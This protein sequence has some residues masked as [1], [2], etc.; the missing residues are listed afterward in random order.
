MQMKKPLVAS[1]DKWEP[2][3]REMRKGDTRKRIHDSG[4]GLIF[5]EEEDWSRYLAARTIVH[6]FE[7]KSIIL[8]EADIAAALEYGN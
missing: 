5:V 1:T 2:Y 6:E 8:A 7:A 3:I 4:C